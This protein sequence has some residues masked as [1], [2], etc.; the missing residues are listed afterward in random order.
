[1]ICMQIYKRDSHVVEVKIRARDDDSECDKGGSETGH[2]PFVTLV[3]TEAATHRCPYLGK[4]TA[5]SVTQ[6][7]RGIRDACGPGGGQNSFNTLIVGCGDRAKMEFHS[8]CPSQEP[9]T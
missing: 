2:G 3:T 1:M 7:G 4:Y 6:D 8:K 5:T 9:T